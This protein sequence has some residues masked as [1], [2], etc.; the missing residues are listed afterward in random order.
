[1]NAAVFQNKILK[2]ASEPQQVA[3]ASAISAGITISNYPTIATH[4]GR[5]GFFVPYTETFPLVPALRKLGYDVVACP[6]TGRHI[7]MPMTSEERR[8]CQKNETVNAQYADTLRAILDSKQQIMAAM[9]EMSMSGPAI[10]RIYEFGV[11]R[12]AP[13]LLVFLTEKYPSHIPIDLV[14]AAQTYI[15]KISILRGDGA[16]G[17]FRKMFYSH[18]K[19]SIFDLSGEKV[20]VI[21]HRL[22]VPALAA[23]EF[24]VE[25][26]GDDSPFLCVTFDTKTNKVRAN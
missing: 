2:F 17:D 25:E 19:N 16:I 15:S 3:I 10:E 5:R 7:V 11:L 18:V 22:N 8:L 9:A 1:M 23:G 24:A 26:V 12:D 20:S 14:Q 6:L 21:L 4:D 13:S